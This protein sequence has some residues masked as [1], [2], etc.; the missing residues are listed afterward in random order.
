MLI[1]HLLIHMKDQCAKQKYE[2]TKSYFPKLN[3]YM[4]QGDKKKILGNF[5]LH[6]QAPIYNTCVFFHI[7]VKDIYW[8]GLKYQGLWHDLTWQ[9]F[10]W[11]A[12]SCC[13]W[14]TF[15][16]PLC[17]LVSYLYRLLSL[18]IW[19]TWQEKEHDMMPHYPPCLDTIGKHDMQIIMIWCRMNLRSLEMRICIT[20][21]LV[22]F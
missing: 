11:L 7:Y 15:D 3:E 13:L 18:C 17:S 20:T 16:V 6:C 22:R 14:L 21:V 1:R 10:K 19:K 5:L 12:F 9:G 4:N 8:E 2:N